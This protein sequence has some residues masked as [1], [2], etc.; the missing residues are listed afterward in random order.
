MF[1]KLSKLRDVFKK[2][3]DSAASLLTSKDKL[4][5]LLE[6]LKLELISKDVAYE[7]AED[8]AS[9][10]RVLILEGKIRDRKTL[11]ESLRGIISSYFE[12]AGSVDLLGLASVKKPFKILFMGVNGVGKT[13]TIAKVAVYFR[14]QGLRPLMVAA[15]TFRAAAQ[16]Q[17]KKHSERTGIPVFM[18]KYGVDPASVAYDAIQFA[19][20]RGFDVL[21]VDTAGRMHTDV[22]LVNELRKIARVVK[23]DFKLLVVDA[24]TGNDAVEQARFFNEAV[25]VDGFIVT[26]FDA[27]EEGGVPISLVYVLKKPVIYV[28]TGQSYRDLKPFN[29]LEYLDKVLPVEE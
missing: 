17:L 7:A 12:N 21:L 10:L 28:G 22:D 16:E 11:V 29:Y 6:D 26:K 8:I 13:T 23:P 27:Y 1:S 25:G 2:F 4:L 20:S 3:I 5:D 15:D 18:G 14:E 19:Q 24:L 9:K